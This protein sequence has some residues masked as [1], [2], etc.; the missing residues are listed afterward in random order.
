MGLWSG[1]DILRRWGNSMNGCINK[2]YLEEG[3]TKSFSSRATVT[4]T[5]WENEVFGVSWFR[6]CSCLVRVQA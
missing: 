2:S 5:I 4:H 3:K 6:Q 1:L